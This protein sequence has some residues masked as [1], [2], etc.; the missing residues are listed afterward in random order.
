M[1]A[2]QRLEI[3]RTLAENKIALDDAVAKNEEDNLNAYLDHQRKRQQAMNATLEVASSVFGSLASIS[4]NEMNNDKR[5]D[6]E[7]KKAANAYATMSIAQATVDTYKSANEAYAAMASIPYVGPALGTAAAGA[8]I[9]AGIANVKQIIQTAQQAKLSASASLSLNSASSITPPTMDLNPVTY[10]RNLLGDK[11]T[12]EL[13]NPIRC[14]VL[15]SDIT[16]TQA[17]VE[18]RESNASF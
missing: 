8:A 18:V 1:S 2:D 5:S 11:E 15:E 17:R 10:T 9:L 3:E 6:R 12:E 16:T 13:N 4:Q 14:Y 7:R